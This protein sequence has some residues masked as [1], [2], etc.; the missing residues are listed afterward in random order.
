MND[1]M[2]QY[3][4]AIRS[5]ERGISDREATVNML[6]GKYQSEGIWDHAEELLAIEKEVNTMKVQLGSKKKRL[7][8]EREAEYLKPAKVDDEPK[9]F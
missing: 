1:M 8:E 2:R 9:L 5:L 7:R 6:I 4:L 3:A